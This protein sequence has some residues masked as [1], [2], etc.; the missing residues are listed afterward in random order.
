MQGIVFVSVW[1]RVFWLI[2]LKVPLDPL[3]YVRRYQQFS[4]TFILFIK[5]YF[6]PD[7]ILVFYFPLPMHYA[8]RRQVSYRSTWIPN[9]QSTANDV[10]NTSSWRRPGYYHGVQQG[11]QIPPQVGRRYLHNHS[12][13]RSAGTWMCWSQPG[14]CKRIGYCDVVEYTFLRSQNAA[15]GACWIVSGLTG[16]A[17]KHK[18]AT[19][20]L[21]SGYA[22]P[23]VG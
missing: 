18:I 23:P 17:W 3:L 16:A 22:S 19:N 8:Q 1:A 15:S 20:T 11:R 10:S 21:L 2:D 5:W 7:I 6:S 9:Q 12:P 13:L 4:S 14:L